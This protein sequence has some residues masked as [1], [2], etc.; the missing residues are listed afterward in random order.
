LLDARCGDDPRLRAEVGKL[1]ARADAAPTAD[2]LGGPS[3]LT[4]KGQWL[5]GD[6]L[7][8]RQVGP[9][10]IQRQLAAGGVGCVYLAARRRDY[11][12]QV[13]VKWIKPGLDAGDVLRRFRA[14]RQLLAGLNH[15]NIAR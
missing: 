1:L 12:Q 11:L 4:F 9:Y 13:A 7:V 6:P 2:F 5:P 15:P 3:P 8:G 10:E 14:E